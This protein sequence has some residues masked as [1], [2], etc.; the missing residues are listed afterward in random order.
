MNILHTESSTGWG[1]QEI[2]ILTEMRGMM[3]RGHQVMLLAPEQAPILP[4]AHKRGIPATGLPIAKKR[5]PALRAL[6]RWLAKHGHE[7]DIINTHSSTDAWLTALA[8][9]SLPA[10][11]PMV[12]TRHVST[13][14]SNRPSTRWLYK[15]ATSHIVTTGEVLRQRL[16][17][18]NGFDLA[19]MTSVRTGIDLSYFQPIQQSEARKRLGLGEQP[20]LGVL[21]ALIDRKGH[22][23]LLDAWQVVSQQFPEWKL[24]II[25][26]GPR[27]SHL[28]N[29]IQTQ[30]LESSVQ[31]VGRQADVTLWLSALDLFTLPTWGDEGV[32]QSVM[33]AVACG[34][35]VVTTSVGA[36]AEAVLN[37]QTGLIVPP[38]VKA[39]LVQALSRLMADRE[40]RRKMGH[41]GLEYARTH[42]GIEQML[43][44][45]EHVFRQVIQETELR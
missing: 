40:L 41:A 3:A 15:V 39:S 10:M 22:D 27:R 18:Y 42:F 7:F 8:C 21:S 38:R 9:R 17:Q 23:A 20:L 6:R 35:P 44:K 25:G 19:R 29:R 4:E 28:E 36:M 31:L 5:I 2:R 24:I 34:L 14:I 13:Q 43:D 32:P 45:M 37:E 30:R 12:R 33:Q 16:H 11:P 1:G 26:D